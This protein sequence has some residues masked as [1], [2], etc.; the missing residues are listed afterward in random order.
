MNEAIYRFIE[1][2]E[3]DRRARERMQKIVTRCLRTAESLRI[4]QSVACGDEH[5]DSD[6]ASRPSDEGEESSIR[7]ADVPTKREVRSAVLEAEAA[8]K[9]LQAALAGLSHKDRRSVLPATVNESALLFSPA[10]KVAPQPN[11]SA[12]Q[13]FV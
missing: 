9:N 11:V 8:A 1:A 6:L 4:L 2:Q 3:R 13:Q 5:D 7:A 10:H 12:D